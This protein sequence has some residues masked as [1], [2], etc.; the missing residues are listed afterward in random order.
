[1]LYLY[2]EGD[3][4]EHYIHLGGTSWLAYENGKGILIDAGN[5]T[6]AGHIIKRIRALG[7]EIPLIFLTHTHYDHAR[8]AE[9]VRQATGAKVVAGAEEL[10]ALGNGRTPVPVGTGRLGRFLVRMIRVLST[11][12]QDH[13]PSVRKMLSRSLRPESLK[14]SALICTCTA[15]AL[16]PPVPSG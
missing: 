11:T 15:L 16:I 14:A 5:N 13:Y 10:D 9:A 8:G 4:I 6:N 1:M 2:G 3:L 7:L 12:S